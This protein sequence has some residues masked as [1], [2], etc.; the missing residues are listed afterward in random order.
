[1]SISIN[2]VHRQADSPTTTTGTQTMKNLVA[3]LS[4]PPM[5]SCRY[6][7]P[8]RVFIAMRT[9]LVGVATF[10]DTRKRRVRIENVQMSIPLC[11]HENRSQ[12]AERQRKV[13]NETFDLNLPYEFDHGYRYISKYYY[14][15]VLVLIAVSIAGIRTH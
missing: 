3:S 7:N 5:A 8:A 11:D 12:Q 14:Y 2:K 15:Q 4:T 13:A 1:M 6:M 10:S 9:T